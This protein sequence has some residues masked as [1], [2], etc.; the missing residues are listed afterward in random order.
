MINLVFLC[1]F[2]C[3]ASSGI[4]WLF[5]GH[6]TTRNRAKLREGFSVPAGL[7]VSRFL[8]GSYLQNPCIS[9]SHWNAGALLP[10]AT[11]P[12]LIFVSQVNLWCFLYLLAMELRR[13]CFESERFKTPAAWRDLFVDQNIIECACYCYIRIRISCHK[14]HMPSYFHS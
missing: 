7:R 1:T 6:Q 2:L 3:F 14:P 11:I 12:P 13:T 5:R 8:F 4:V 10:K 9:S